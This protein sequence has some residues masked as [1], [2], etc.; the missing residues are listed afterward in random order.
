MTN[1]EN[2]CRLVILPHLDKEYQNAV[3]RLRATRSS[4]DTPERI[5]DVEKKLRAYR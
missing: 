1:E 5:V 2:V 4:G 3:N